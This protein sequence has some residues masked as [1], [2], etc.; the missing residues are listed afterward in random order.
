MPRG[1]PS[2]ADMSAIE[3]IEALCIDPETDRPFV[4]N[5]AERA[6]LQHAFT[7]KPD[8]RPLYPELVYSAPKKS[9]KTAFAALML[10]YIVRVLGGR[11]A[12]AWCAANDLEIGRA[13]CRERVFLSV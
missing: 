2:L 6:F 12:E 3:F 13:S 11:Y 5:D 7:L 8:G 9:G 4:L 1:G 10:I